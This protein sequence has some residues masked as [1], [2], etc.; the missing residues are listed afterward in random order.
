MNFKKIL[1]PVTLADGSRAAVA[2]AANLAKESG[3]SLALLHAVQLSIAGEERGIPRTRLVDDLCREA[4]SQLRQLLQSV[5]LQTPT[6]IIVR[7]GRPAGMIVES[8]RCLAVD[9]IVMFTHGYRGWLRW[10]HRNTALQV[11]RHAPCPVWLVSP[12]RRDGI[13]LVLVD[14]A[15]ANQCEKPHEDA[16][17]PQS[18]LRV[19]VS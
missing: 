15:T 18:V 11:L 13:S 6:E 10:L 17:P 9:A 7:E 8:A 19:S 5:T 4:E 3:A 1:V 14:R 16:G 2:V 12:G